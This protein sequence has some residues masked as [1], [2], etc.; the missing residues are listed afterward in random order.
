MNEKLLDKLGKLITAREGE[1]AIG[2]EAA[3]EAFAGAINRLLL[4]HDLSL[5]DVEHAARLKDDPIVEVKANLEKFGVDLKQA[6]VGW[7]EAMAQIVAKAHLCEFLI[8]RGANSVWFVGTREHVTV[9]EYAYGTLVAAVDKLSWDAYNKRFYGLKGRGE[10]VR[11][12]RG[13]RASWLA[14]FVVRI[15][16]R[17]KEAQMGAFANVAPGVGLMRINQSLAKA[18]A[19]VDAKFAGKPSIPSAR[20]DKAR[21]RTGWADGKRAADSVP[22]DRRGMGAAMTAGALGDGR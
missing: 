12:A 21:D 7:Q 4:A 8:A 11:L 10:D 13:Y 19:H 2:N 5:S 9:A 20:M 14:A 15:A 1:A 16:E 6:R 18:K 3:A 22:L 17:F